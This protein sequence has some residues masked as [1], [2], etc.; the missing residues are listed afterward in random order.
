MTTKIH[1]YGFYIII[2]VVLWITEFM[3]S[4]T[5]ENISVDELLGFERFPFLIEIKKATHP[6]LVGMQASTTTL[7]NYMEAS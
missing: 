3:F 4:L 5:Y 6:L 7:E 1:I 2:F